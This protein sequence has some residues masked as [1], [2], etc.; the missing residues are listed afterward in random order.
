MALQNCCPCTFLQKPRHQFSVWP[1]GSPINASPVMRLMEIES[2]GSNLMT[3]ASLLI[4]TRTPPGA[5]LHR[6][7]FP[8]RFGDRSQVVLDCTYDPETHIADRVLRL[9]LFW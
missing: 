7:A 9:F 4:V 1:F 3:N 8:S 5:F 6:K 2:S